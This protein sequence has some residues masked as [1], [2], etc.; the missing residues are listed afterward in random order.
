[1]IYELVYGTPDVNSESIV[2]KRKVKKLDPFNSGLYK[3][4]GIFDDLEIIKDSEE[5]IVKRKILE[6]GMA[7]GFGDKVGPFNKWGRKYTF[8]NTDNYPHHPG[9]DPL[10]KSFPFYIFVSKNVKYGVFTDY[11]GFLEI[12]LDSE[13]KNELKFK[14]KGKGFSQYIIIGKSIRE[15]LKQYLFLTGKNAAFPKWAFGYQQSRW[16]YL[17][18]KE[19][20]EVAKKFRKGQIPCDVIYLDIDYMDKYKVFTWNKENFKNY[21]KMIKKLHDDGFKISAI[22]DPGVKVEKN[23]EVFEE[24]KNRYFLK[25]PNGEDFEGAV[26]PGKVRF[27][28]FRERKVRRWWSK[29]VNKL[30]TDGIDGFW[31]DMNEI[32]IFATEKD[33]EE[34][35]DLVNDLKLEDG[36]NLAI[37]A[38]KIGE[39]GRRGRGEEI[40][41][42]DGTIHYKVKNTYGFNMIRAAYDGFGKNE[43]RMLITRSAYPGV[44]R[45]GGVWTG[46]NHSWWEHINLEMSRLMSLSLDGVFYSGCDVGGFNGDVSAE[47]LIRFMQFGSFIPMFRNHTAWGTRPQEPWAFGKEYED[48]MRKIIEYRYKLI[49]YIYTEYMVGVIKDFPL[50]SP[51]FFNF[52]S[53]ERTYLIDDQFMLGRNLIVC[54]VYK[55]GQDKRI[56]YLPKRVLDLNKRTFL[57]K[58]WSEVE[59]PL[60]EI[61][62]YLIDG[63]ILPTQNVMNYVDEKESDITA[64]VSAYNDKAVGYYYE[65]DGI[66]NNYKKGIYNLYKIIYEKNKIEVRKVRENFLHTKK[67]WKFVIYTKDQVKEI[68]MKI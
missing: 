62:H 12:D 61:P 28:D 41:H 6:K 64:I 17:T 43:R 25:S 14:I 35:K 40:V 56:V 54:P 1:M 20:L 32:S 42:L 19:V 63:R 22:I 49:P 27:P 57:N 21:K 33:I 48:L 4:D 68:E 26:W 30:H 16:S 39:I 67:L 58:G 7:F 8:W 66:S 37:K 45:Y 18:E 31:N 65:D 52:E 10:Y 24:G 50:L 46:D 47:L 5:L 44:Q 3:I 11:P 13:G 60:E 29:K 55:P 38:G 36:I 2:N 23:Y 34:I 53:D 59:A 51:M 9:A 15:I